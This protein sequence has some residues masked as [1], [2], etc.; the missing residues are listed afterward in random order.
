MRGREVADIFL[1]Y[2]HLDR[3]LAERMA[4]LLQQAGLT[5]WWDDDVTPREEW[6]RTIER[7]IAAAKFVLV[8]WT[9]NSVE[10]NW[11]RIEA[12]YGKDCRPR[13]LVQ[14]RFDG[15]SIPMG[16]SLI[17]H[18]DLS[19]SDPAGDR[20]WSKL[21]SWLGVV[22]RESHA[23]TPPPSPAASQSTETYRSGR[24]DSASAKA[25][26]IFALLMVAA[27]FLGILNDYLY[28]LSPYALAFSAAIFGFSYPI[29]RY[30]NKT[31]QA[32]AWIFPVLMWIS[33]I[34]AENV[35]IYFYNGGGVRPEK[36]IGAAW[37][38]FLM[39]AIP[40]VGALVTGLLSRSRDSLLIL[41]GSIIGLILF[42]VVLEY[43]GDSLN[44]V[45]EGKVVVLPV[46]LVYYLPWH[47]AFALVCLR[48][49]RI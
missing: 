26:I 48:L 1:S 14:A 3:A 45:P 4:A 10:S 34:S 38:G 30:F 9:R 17:Q 7:E 13:K 23:P 35:F 2:Q 6:D 49:L 41:A 5:V 44:V 46:L 39:A 29:A 42:D 24:D 18:I 21:L 11:V 8:L 33:S 43:W 19:R 22:P 28:N 15:C 16:Y 37:W 32:K 25:K 12:N 47:V 36:M 20:A 40:L 31:F 27:I